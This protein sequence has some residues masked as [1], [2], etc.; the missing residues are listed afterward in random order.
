MLK[1]IAE[2][3]LYVE[4]T[5]FRNVNVEKPDQLLK[6]IRGEQG[7][8][9]VQFFSA[10][11]VA[12]WEHLYFAVIDALMAFRTKRNISKSLA[13][14]IMLYASAQRQIKKAIEVVGVKSGASDIAVVIVSKRHQTVESTVASVSKHFRKEPDE[15]VLGFS[16]AKEKAIREAFRITENELSAVTKQNN[17]AR[18]LVDL[19]V[20]RMALLSTRL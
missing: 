12:T 7:D 15:Q 6:A 10:E 3:G 11:L 8:V 16:S 20:E 1:Q 18:A 9:D 19:V 13:V 5:G 4:I 2:E 14:E 17:R